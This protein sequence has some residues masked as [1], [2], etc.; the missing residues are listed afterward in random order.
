MEV[1]YPYLYA[2][3]PAVLTMA[4]PS[5]ATTRMSHQ[6]QPQS[7]RF[8]TSVSHSGCPD[9]PCGLGESPVGAAVCL[10]SGGGVFDEDVVSDNRR[11]F[12]DRSYEKMRD[13]RSSCY[14]PNGYLKKEQTDSSSPT[15]YRT[16]SGWADMAEEFEKQTSIIQGE[17]DRYQKKR[18]RTCSTGSSEQED[19]S[20]A[21]PAM[22]E[23][24]Q[25][26][27]MRRQ[28]QID[29]GKNTL[30][31]D[32]YSQNTPR[33]ARKKDDPW[34]PTKFAVCSRRAWDGR[35]KEWRKKLHNW[36]PQI[37]QVSASAEGIVE[38][39][40]CLDDVPDLELLDPMDIDK[41]QTFTI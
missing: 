32:N 37:E 22:C 41:E 1:K 40:A 14:K 19:N 3:P 33:H 16:K 4:T 18:H 7:E 31:Y 24:D 29:Y 26:T 17:L 10:A 15:A 36:D 30:A 21:N 5:P 20:K 23:T 25:V 39:E 38:E 12:R 9:W 28:K 6:V 2:I 35:I 27:L 8:H 11:P 13:N 34:T